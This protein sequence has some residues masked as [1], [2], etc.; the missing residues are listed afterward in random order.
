MAAADRSLLDWIEE[1]ATHRGLHFAEAG[2]TWQFWSYAQLAE[3]SL[4]AASAFRC[5]DL[6]DGNVIAIIQPSSPGFTASLFGALSAGLTACSVAPPFAIRRREEYARHISHLLSVSRPDLVVCDAE[7]VGALRGPLTALNLAHVVFSDLIDQVPAMDSPREPTGTA[8]LQFT[9]GSSGFSRGVRIS[10]H[11]LRANLDA[12][13]HWLNWDASQPGISWLPV[14]H[15]MGLVGCLLNAVVTS[16]D[17]YLMQPDDFIRSP[18]RYLTCISDHKVMM[19]AMPNFGLA[20]ILHRIRSEQL[21][22]LRFDSLRAIIL[23]AERIDSRVLDEFERLLGPYG[24]DRRALLPSYGSAEATLAIAG[25]A[26]GTGWRTASP[27]HSS[28]GTGKTEAVGC[29]RPLRGI[30]VAIMGEDGHQVAPGEVGEIVISGPSIAS[31]Y[32]QPADNASGSRISG[33]TLRSGDAGF[34]VDGELFVIG[35]LGDGLKVRGRMVFA[36]TLEMALAERGIPERRMAVLLGIAGDRQAGVV[37]FENEQDG[38]APIAA[39]VLGV[40]LPDAELTVVS[41]PRGSLAVTSSGKPRRRVMWQAF[42]ESRLD[43]HSV[44]S[45]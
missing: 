25:L 34:M 8:L 9:S 3:L 28:T 36:E 26:P 19:T 2:G 10:A 44:E 38:W 40:A 5:R 22:D 23:G 24:L 42:L 16:S 33:R 43:G 1:S 11:A 31:G 27:D 37:V 15:D 20:Y 17:T 4:R 39:D 30:T 32:V 14:H 21:R 41:V 12:M 29:G 13:R 18:L 7:S 45:R 35:R 6:T